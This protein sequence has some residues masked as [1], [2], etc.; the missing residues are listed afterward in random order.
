MTGPSI[1]V[2]IVQLLAGRWRYSSEEKLWLIGR[3]L[4]K[5]ND[6]LTHDNRKDRLNQTGLWL[7]Y[8]YAVF[9]CSNNV[10]VCVNCIHLK[11]PDSQYFDRLPCRGRC[12]KT[13][14]NV[15]VRAISSTLRILYPA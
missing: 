7:K 4:F 2:Q 14:T 5:R 1:L 9:A 8:N 3:K 12:C 6:T 15:C 11:Y 10:Y 13:C